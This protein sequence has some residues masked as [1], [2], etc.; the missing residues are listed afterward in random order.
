[1][2]REIKFRIW[3]KKKGN[4][5]FIKD[6]LGLNDRIYKR[7]KFDLRRRNDYTIQQYTGIKDGRGI[8]I[9]EGDIIENIN[10]DPTHNSIKKQKGP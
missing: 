3:D 8:E 10:K 7:K 5:I 1:M 2:E 6:L 4:F 9:Y